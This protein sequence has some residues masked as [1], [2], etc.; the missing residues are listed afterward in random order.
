MFKLKRIFLAL[1][2]AQFIFSP[3]L[4]NFIPVTGDPNH[5]PQAAS[6]NEIA[7]LVEFTQSVINGYSRQVV[8]I[9]STD[10][11]ALPVTQQPSGNPAFVSTKKEIVTQ[12][13]QAAQYGSIGLVAHNYLAGQ[14][15]FNL[16]EGNI[17]TLIYG[18]GT[19]VDYKITS[20]EEYQALNPTSPYS[21]YIDLS[22]P[23]KTLTVETVFAQIYGVKGR[24]IL[25]TCISKDNV[26]SWGRLFV[27][28]EPVQTIDSDQEE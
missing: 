26:D 3:I 4:S 9:Y 16:A 14:Y 28:A 25:Q 1:F 17:L 11:F 15:F 23:D 20:I 18:D 24:M 13:S 8:G 7:S 22:Q 10:N 2:V 12:F 5:E 6:T 19:Q 27:I 21:K